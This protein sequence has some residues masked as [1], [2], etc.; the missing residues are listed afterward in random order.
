MPIDRH[1]QA[2]R[3]LLTGYF[4]RGRHVDY[5]D[6]D[7]L[8]PKLTELMQEARYMGSMDFA[9]WVINHDESSF[10]SERAWFKIKPKLLAGYQA[11]LMKGLK[12]VRTNAGLD[13]YATVH[14]LGFKGKPLSCACQT[15]SGYC[16]CG[17]PGH[18]D[19]RNGGAI[20]IAVKAWRV[21]MKFICRACGKGEFTADGDDQTCP[22]CGQAHQVIVRMP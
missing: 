3:Q 8:A 22:E 19:G 14:Q 12:Q 4:G 16:A 2:V 17:L 6:V 11:D 10:R 9:N 1:E 21:N 13:P 7:Y 15:C 18:H 5:L 20:E